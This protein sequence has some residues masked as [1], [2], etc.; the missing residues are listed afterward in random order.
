M[1]KRSRVA[2]AAQPSHEQKTTQRKVELAQTLRALNSQFFGWVRQQNDEKPAELW[3]EGVEDYITHA[4]EILSEFA[5]V[6]DGQESDSDGEEA[7]PAPAKFGGARPALDR[8]AL[9]TAHSPFGNGS[10]AAGSAFG[11]AGSTSGGSAPAAPK[12]DAPGGLFGGSGTTGAGGPSVSKPSTAAP[13]TFGSGS[14]G[15]GAFGSGGGFGGAKTGAAPPASDAAAEQQPDSIARYCSSLDNGKIASPDSSH[16][17][18]PPTSGVLD[19]NTFNGGGAM[20]QTGALPA[21]PLFGTPK[22]SSGAPAEIASAPPMFAFGGPAFGG[23]AVSG[24]FGG[25]FGSGNPA[26]SSPAAE[27]VGPEAAV[28]KQVDG[29][30]GRAASPGGAGP[31][32]FGSSSTKLPDFGAAFKSGPLANSTAAGNAASGSMFSGAFESAAPASGPLPTMFSFGA[33]APSGGAPRAGAAKTAEEDDD[34]QLD[35]NPEDKV[36]VALDE[37]S[38][39]V[40]FRET[41]K[42]YFQEKGSNKWVD[43]G[44]GTLTLRRERVPDGGT[45]TSS[46]FIVVTTDSGRVLLSANLYSNMTLTQP[47]NKQQM[48]LAAL[49]LVL[50]EGQVAVLTLVN[51]RLDSAEKG[52]AFY[53]AVQEHKPK[54]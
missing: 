34:G 35:E 13:S 37:T 32:T 22:L 21:T 44:R 46:P 11:L 26:V 16:K 42:V 29:S 30:V 39:E 48:V 38:N 54:A 23:G 18:Q 47:P 6:V 25:G 19:A 52:N 8:P 31:S 51:F 49:H 17:S 14:F 50:A 36:T 27:G 20:G 12:P 28:W 1:G 41:A 15:G 9:G 3:S 45:S 5:D 53:A 4:K 10:S 33:P 40:L 24:G 43:K 7:A 2:E